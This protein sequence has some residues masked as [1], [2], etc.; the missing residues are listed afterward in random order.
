MP[1]AGHTGGGDR[2][3]TG[4]WGQQER[5]G[6]HSRWRRPRRH[7]SGENHLDPWIGYASPTITSIYTHLYPP[8]PPSMAAIWGGEGPQPPNL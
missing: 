8:S 5:A 4:L 6:S 7:G 3:L 2:A 1:W